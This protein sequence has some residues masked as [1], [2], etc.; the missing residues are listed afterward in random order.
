MGSR[1]VAHSD[2]HSHTDC[3][4]T[5]TAMT[6]S[7][8]LSG[9]SHFDALTN[10]QCSPL[11]DSQPSLDYNS[12]ELLFSQPAA[13][14]NLKDI[15][16]GDLLSVNTDSELNSDDDDILTSVSACKFDFTTGNSRQSSHAD[17]AMMILSELLILHILL[18]VSSD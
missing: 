12:H 4:N 6:V 1:S 17:V 18:R 8:S 10:V 11:G 15:N 5:S 2:E 16:S 14:V 3:S 13:G 9:D 7:C